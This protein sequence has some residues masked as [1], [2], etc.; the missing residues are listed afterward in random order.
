MNKYPIFTMRCRTCGKEYHIYWDDNG[1]FPR[2][3]LNND[4]QNKVFMGMFKD[5]SI[6]GRP[7]IITNIYKERMGP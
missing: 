3:M 2:P 7:K 4:H 5:E 1:N 6:K